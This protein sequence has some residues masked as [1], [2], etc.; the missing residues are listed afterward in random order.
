MTGEPPPALSLRGIH[1]T[2]GGVTAIEEFNLDVRAGEIVALVGD[3]GAG[4]STLIKIVAGVQPATRG[5]IRI[6]GEL[7]DLRTPADS[8]ACGIQV[9]YQDLALAERQPVYMNL[10]LGREL[11]PALARQARPPP[12]DRRDRKPDARPRRAHPLRARDG[13]AICRA[14]SARALRLR[15]QP[16]GR[17]SWC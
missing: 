1:K 3:N 17:P 6:D 15:A 16:I 5:E 9:V 12:H 13:R 2:F 10:F 8:Q 7:A 4:K 11:T 14:A